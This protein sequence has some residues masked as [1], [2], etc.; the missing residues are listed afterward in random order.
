MGKLGKRIRRELVKSPAKSASLGLVCLVALWYWVPILFDWASGAPETPPDIRVVKPTEVGT[1]DTHVGPVVAPTTALLTTS[2]WQTLAKSMDDD[3]ST[4]SAE[5]PEDQRDPFGRLGAGDSE[6]TLEQLQDEIDDE[7]TGGLATAKSSGG[8]EPDVSE[9]KLVLG[10]TIIGGRFRSATING[11]SYQEGDVVR[12]A[13]NAN[14]RASDGA[15]EK[16][17]E[18]ELADVQASHVVLKRGEKEYL[19]E[20][21]RTGLALGDRIVRRVAAER[22]NAAET[23]E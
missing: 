18:W 9:L 15:T 7:P 17:I 22:I 19:L 13:V 1:T 14:S 4:K 6:E 20:L 23:K 5:L 3:P 21:Q 12:V 11:S 16:E 2:N 10:G 8:N